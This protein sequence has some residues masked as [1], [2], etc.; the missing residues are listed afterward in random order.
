MEN[1]SQ[2]NADHVVR[3]IVA[4]SQLE[5]CIMGSD[6]WLHPCPTP[7]FR[8]NKKGIVPRLEV[9]SITQLDSSELDGNAI[10]YFVKLGC[11]PS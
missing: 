11:V 6:A 1:L 3:W 10:F 9:V 2:S 7:H 5:F 4:W 8:R